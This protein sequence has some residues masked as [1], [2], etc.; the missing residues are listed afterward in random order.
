[1]SSTEAEATSTA[2]AAI[3]AAQVVVPC[4]DLDE[5]I[6]F[7]T[8]TLGFRVDAIHPADAP[9][10]AVLS[11]HGLQLRLDRHASG[12]PGTLRVLCRDAVALASLA[13]LASLAGDGR[14]IVAPNGT[15]IE[16]VDAAAGV[17][18][19]PV[20]QSLVISRVEGSSE[21]KV[22][23]A[24]MHYRDLIPDRQGGRFIASHIAIPDGGPVPDY[25][26]FHKVRFQMIYCHRGWARLVYEDQGAPFVI[27][28]G[29][30]V[31]QPPEIRH[32]VLE[33]SP[34]LQVIE[35]GCPAEHE[36]LADHAME[37]PNSR[38]ER[39]RSFAGQRFVW[40]RAAAATW[41]PWRQAGFEHCD[42]GIARVTDGLAGVRTVRP[43]ATATAAISSSDDVV[44][45]LSHDGEFAFL[46][47]LDGAV[48]IAIDGREPERL[49]TDD[50]IVIPAGLTHALHEPTLDLR[51]LDVTLPG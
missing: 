28:T 37:L 48:T 31:I 23:R 3:T 16:L 46:F 35:I 25:V 50:C 36:T 9:S 2:T 21:W 44:T 49:S 32:R 11:G 6:R 39:D 22:G 29:D 14:A 20:Q 5:T 51:L 47:V 13:S 18:V 26:H 4:T 15:V 43:T 12:S 40:H 24:G 30:C 38:V 7:F 42:T 33:A 27:E 19:P 45:P 1:M 17:V 34:G 8:R 10:V 41:Q